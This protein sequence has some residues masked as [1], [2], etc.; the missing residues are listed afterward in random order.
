MLALQYITTECWLPLF[1]QLLRQSVKAEQKG[2]V[3]VLYLFAATTV[4]TLSAYLIDIVC[5][6]E[7]DSLGP[8]NFSTPGSWQGFV[9]FLFNFI[10]LVGAVPFF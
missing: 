9:I 1:L 8:L 2:F 3:T 10:S 6:A 7:L 4:A 5:G